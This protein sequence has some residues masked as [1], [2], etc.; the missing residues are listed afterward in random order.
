MQSFENRIDIILAKCQLPITQLFDEFRR[1]ISVYSSIVL[2]AEPGA[3]KTT[4]IPLLSLKSLQSGKIIVVEPRRVAAKTAAMRMADMLSETVGKTVGYRVRNESQCSAQTR[5]EVITEGVLIRMVQNDPEL[6]GVSAVIF[7]E[8]HERSLQADLSLALV[9]ET[10]QAIRDD[11]KLIIMSATINAD[12]LTARLENSTALHSSGRMFPVEIEYLAPPRYGNWRD[13][14]VTAVRRGLHKVHGDILVFLPGRGEIE[15]SRKQIE[16]GCMDELQAQSIEIFALHGE[17]SLAEQNKLLKSNVEYRRIILATNIAET[18]VT[19]E[20]VELV[21]DSGLVK[22]LEFDVGA[23][24][25]KLVTRQISRASAE[26]R[27]GR[28]GRIKEGVCYRLWSESDVLQPFT[29]PEIQRVDLT[30]FVLELALWGEMDTE[31]FI[32]LDQPKESSIS[33]ARQ[34]LYELNALTDN[35]K[36]SKTGKAMVS[37]GTHPRMGHLLIESSF[38]WTACLLAALLEERE[39]VDDSFRDDPNIEMRLELLDHWSQKDQSAK[40]DFYLLKSSAKGLVNRILQQAN[41]WFNHERQDKKIDVSMAGEYLAYAFPDRIA[42]RI[43][44]GYQLRNGKRVSLAQ[45]E[46]ALSEFVVIPRMTFSEKGIVARLLGN[47][48]KMRIESLFANQIRTLDV[49]EW[50]EHKTEFLHQKLLGEIILS[51]KRVD[52]PDPELI[53]KGLITF[54]KREGIKVLPWS[55]SLQQLRRRVALIKKYSVD[56]RLPDLSDD[57][58]TNNIDRWLYPFLNGISSFKEISDELLKQAISSLLTWEQQTLV[59]ELAPER[60]P[61]ASGSNIRLD[62]RDDAA[63]V[64]AVKLQELF[65]EVQTPTIINGTV[66]VVLHLLSPAGRPLQ[67]TEDLVS[68]WNNGYEQVKKEMKGRYPKH[69]WP[70]DPMS[71]QATRMT[72]KQLEKRNSHG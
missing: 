70:D 12:L 33:R 9:Y 22:L 65:G 41:R 3:G 14:L 21:I 31:Q 26:Q 62:Y 66:N 42:K 19:I 53:T 16:S 29:I 11:L 48:E 32:F 44:D 68:F 55:K 7:D 63:P 71:A 25:D 4:C 56:S 37:L 24:L 27:S 46:L 51:S 43:N 20:G 72:K 35:G 28:A 60:Y 30:S 45:P 67:I 34:L 8:F 61:V 1:A 54:I 52:D 38:Q 58:L 17:L 57:G 47:I 36:I 10:Q 5:I 13:V 2:S 50:Q 64:L 23:G 15:W 59:N 40:S 69:P 49:A 6:A 18:S 39:F